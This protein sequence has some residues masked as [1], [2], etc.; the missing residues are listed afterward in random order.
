MEKI[1]WLD[2]DAMVWMTSQKSLFGGFEPYDDKWPRS[3]M[4]ENAVIY[5]LPT[6]VELNSAITAVSLPTPTATAG[7][8][9]Q[10][11]GAG[12]VGPVRLSLGT[13]ASRG[14]WPPPSVKGN[15]HRKGASKQSSDGLATATKNWPTPQAADHRDRGHLGQPVVQ[16]RLSIGKQLNLSMV[17]SDTS[18]KLSPLWVEWLMGFP[19][20]WTAISE[21]EDH[22]QNG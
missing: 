16:R 8:T 17:A 18:G 3:G 12:R 15:Y 2:V 13:M 5:Y 9:N 4:M 20:G 10:G 19:P 6:L 1:A 21:E 22:D 7:G 14:N 11:G